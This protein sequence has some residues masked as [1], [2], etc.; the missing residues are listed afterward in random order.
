MLVIGRR[1]SETI[2]LETPIGIIL[3]MLTDS[4]KNKASIGIEAPSSVKIIR[5]EINDNNDE[6]ESSE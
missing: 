1:I 5:T 6:N 2:T 4:R 3:I